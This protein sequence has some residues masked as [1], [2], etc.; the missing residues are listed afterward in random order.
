LPTQRAFK[1]LVFHL[2]TATDR[3]ALAN[4]QLIGLFNTDS[5]L[6]GTITD[7]GVLSM[8]TSVFNALP[9]GVRSAL[10]SGDPA[11]SMRDLESMRPMGDENI[12]TVVG[13]WNTISRR[14]LSDRVSLED[15]KR[16]VIST[17]AAALVALNGDTQKYW[18]S[19]TS[20]ILNK[21]AEFVYNND[22]DVQKLNGF[23]SVL[24]QPRAESGLKVK[25]ITG[26]KVRYSVDD[27]KHLCL[28]YGVACAV[29]GLPD[30]KQTAVKDSFESAR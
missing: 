11:A 24:L 17:N 15:W 20:V 9:A 8:N 25:R 14:H 2:E 22:E 29:W 5:R 18:P 19:G 30:A 27:C 16:A 6:E 13:V 3:R 10:R 4:T 7:E 23:V 1:P 28:A 26:G 21:W 12:N